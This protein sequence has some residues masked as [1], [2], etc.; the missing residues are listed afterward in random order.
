MD[1]EED[2]ENRPNLRRRVGT[3]A[4][5]QEGGKHGAESWL[6]RHVCPLRVSD[7]LHA[8][9]SPCREDVRGAGEAGAG[10]VPGPRGGQGGRPRPEERAHGEETL[11]I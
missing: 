6:T 1:S 5:K 2:C 8:S 4:A 7:V 3:Y 9:A 10:S 11:M